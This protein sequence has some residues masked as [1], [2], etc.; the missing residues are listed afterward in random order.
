MLEELVCTCSHRKYFHKQ[1]SQ[2][3]EPNMVLLHIIP[4]YPTELLLKLFVILYNTKE[5]I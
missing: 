1:A 4:V 2:L 3:F 5:S